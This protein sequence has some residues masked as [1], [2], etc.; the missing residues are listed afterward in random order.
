[1]DI[2][3]VI[4]MNRPSTY[5]DFLPAVYRADE[6]AGN[7]GFL[8]MFLKIY[9]KLLTGID[10]CV[11][12]QALQAGGPPRPVSVV[13]LEEI[14]ARL[15]DYFDP[16]FTPQFLH[17][18]R[19]QASFV[20]YLSSW[21]ALLQN[22]SW[23]LDSQRRLL[24]AIVPLYKQRGTATGLTQYLR[25][26]LRPFPSATATVQEDLEGIQVGVT[27]SLGLNTVV[28]G[29][30]PFFFFV[31]LDVSVLNGFEEFSNLVANTRAIV[32]LEK[33]AHTYYS[34]LYRVPGFTVGG[35][36]TVGLDTMIGTP[37]GLLM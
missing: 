23:D 10:D 19:D 15:H 9:E 29:A 7:A 12:P 31:K 36:S 14:V 13:G 16:L 20:A 6:V 22:Q 34:F 30:P 25:L 27:A 4:P 2:V 35:P 21:V 24:A 17:S 1:M 28:G 8:G 32:D 11:S 37:F 26:Y 3:P 18:A 33:P 5:M